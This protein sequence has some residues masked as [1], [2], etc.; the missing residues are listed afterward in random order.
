M[1]YASA[2]GKRCNRVYNE[3][4]ERESSGM[5]Y[6][7]S[8]QPGLGDNRSSQGMQEDERNNHRP[9]KNELL[10]VLHWHYVL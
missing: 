10:E 8:Q 9:T 2:V 1:E 3:L 4:K 7:E 5:F 6:R